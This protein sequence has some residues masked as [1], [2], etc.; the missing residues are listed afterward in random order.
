MNLILLTGGVR[1]NWPWSGCAVLKD[2]SGPIDYF[3]FLRKSNGRKAVPRQRA[4]TSAYVLKLGG[5]VAQ[6]F[7]DADRTAFRKVD[8]EQPKRDGFA[9]MLAVLR[10][11]PGLLAGDRIGVEGPDAHATNICA[12]RA[13]RCQ[14]AGRRCRATSRHSKVTPRSS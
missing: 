2:V 6:E 4:I 1:P 13:A 5:R 14:R 10:C 12:R 11:R 9:S 8:G 3:L 7:T